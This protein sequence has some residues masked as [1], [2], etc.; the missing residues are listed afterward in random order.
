[1]SDLNWTT[2]EQDFTHQ[3]FMTQAKKLDKKE[4]L[5]LFEHVHKQYQLNHRLFKALMNWCAS[6]GT[7]LPSFDDLLN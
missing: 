6:K 1:M 3:Y 2:T 5:D 4:L 7:G